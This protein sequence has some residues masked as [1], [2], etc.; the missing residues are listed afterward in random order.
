MTQLQT[1]VSNTRVSKIPALR[2]PCTGQRYCYSEAGEKVDC[3]DS[4]QD[5]DIRAGVAWPRDRFVSHGNDQI[6]DRLTGLTWSADANPCEYPVMW[7]EALE[8]ILHLNKDSYL[9]ANDWRMPNRRELRSLVSY[10]SARPALPAGH[11]FHNVFPGWYWSSTSYA[12]NPAHAWYVH[13]DG[14][15]MFYGG[16]DQSFLLWPVRG[17]GNGLLARTGQQH[18]FSPAGGVM[19]C[20]GQQDGA[21]QDGRAWPQPRF[22]TQQQGVVDRLTG[23]VWRSHADLT[24]QAVSWE[25]ALQAVA[26]LNRHEDAVHWYLPNINELES[27]TD[28]SR[29]DPAL[30]G[31]SPFVSVQSAYWSSTTSAY[32]TDWA[33]VL[34]LDKGAV[35]VGQKRGR[36][37]HVWAVSQLRVD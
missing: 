24:E 28:C 16:K 3:R 17:Q 15:R 22:M 6:V 30:P 2:Y 26:E 9:G 12:G 14:A 21:R 5:A 25:E 23:L 7:V 11:P 19:N 10:Q 8:A 4:G 18:C 36:Y 27:L 33:W 13:M 20:A 29:A 35:G 34:Y 32:E 1:G 31:D 37:F